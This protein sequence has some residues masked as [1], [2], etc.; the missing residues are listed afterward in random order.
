MANINTTIKKFTSFGG[1]LFNGTAAAGSR[2]MNHVPGSVAWNPGMRTPVEYT[3]DAAI[4]T[5][6]EGD[7]T[8]GDFEFELYGGSYNA[9]TDP[10]ELFQAYG[11]DGT[12]PLYTFTLRVPDYLGAATGQE[13]SIAN[14]WLAEPPKV[15]TNGGGNQLDTI[16]FKFKHKNTQLLGTTY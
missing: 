13:I 4:A 14:C 15:K 10:Y 6:L 16:A 1:Q 11:T 3:P 8:P 7:P 12:V 5:P 2:I 9:G